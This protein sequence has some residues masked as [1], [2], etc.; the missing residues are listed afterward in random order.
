[1]K[2][3]VIKKQICLRCGHSWFPSK[4]QKPKH[5][6]SCNS[7]L[8]DKPKWKASGPPR[9]LIS[10]QDIQNRKAKFGTISFSD[11]SGTIESAFN[12]KPGMPCPA[13]K[14]MI[15]GT[16]DDARKTMMEDAKAMKEAKEY[17]SK[18]RGKHGK[19]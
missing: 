18:H 14:T 4:P 1:M 9:V 3:E 8:W 12:S 7:P 15:E 16:K 5:C 13:D 11:G 17:Y 19:K 10:Y 6:P 2:E